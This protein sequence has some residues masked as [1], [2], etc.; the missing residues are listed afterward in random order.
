MLSASNSLFKLANLL[1][2]RDLDYIVAVQQTFL[3]AFDE[4]ELMLKLDLF[5]PVF[6][7]VESFLQSWADFLTCTPNSENPSN[8]DLQLHIHYQGSDFLENLSK[9]IYSYRKFAIIVLL[10]EPAFRDRL[11]TLI[12]KSKKLYY[13][14]LSRGD[15]FALQE[16]CFLPFPTTFFQ[17]PPYEFIEEESPLWNKMK[18]LSDDLSKLMP[19]DSC[20]M[21]NSMKADLHDFAILYNCSD[22]FC[23]EC[24]KIHFLNTR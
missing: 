5:Y 23:L 18:G 22:V 6:Y 9:Y 19:E 7:A 14:S 20:K 12:N 3:K 17:E 8:I 24:A 4:A 11:D 15:I 2:E 13:E 21:C 16:N 1:Y 10:D